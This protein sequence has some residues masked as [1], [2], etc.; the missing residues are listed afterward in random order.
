MTQYY[1]S[2]EQANALEDMARKHN[3]SVDTYINV[4]LKEYFGSDKIS[5]EQ[6]FEA[7]LLIKQQN[8][9]E[10]GYSILKV[11]R[12]FGIDCKMDM[13]SDKLYCP[14]LGIC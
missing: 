5:V 7:Q 14:E 9:Y 4:T 11:I 3:E 12:A 2:T 10:K 6:W 13:Q 8:F 1:I